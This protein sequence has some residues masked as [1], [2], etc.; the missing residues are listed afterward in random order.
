MGGETHHNTQTDFCGVA[1]ADGKLHLNQL[2]FGDDDD[3]STT[4]FGPQ[5]TTAHPWEVTYKY[6]PLLT[7]DEGNAVIQFSE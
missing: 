6:N 1:G 4:T 7:L 5:T 3:T 2:W